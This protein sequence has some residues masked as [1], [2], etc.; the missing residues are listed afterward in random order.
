MINNIPYFRLVTGQTVDGV[1]QFNNPFSDINFERGVE[2]SWQKGLSG[3]IQAFNPEK[4]ENGYQN[5]YR[6]NTGKNPLNKKIQKILQDMLDVSKRYRNKLK[7]TCPDKGKDFIISL[8]EQNIFV[9]N[10]PDCQPYKGLV[11]LGNEFYEVQFVKQHGWIPTGSTMNDP[12][13]KK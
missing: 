9:D 4:E 6:R 1:P 10:S 12:K 5:G 11:N 2:T 3:K 13:R 8:N 7:V